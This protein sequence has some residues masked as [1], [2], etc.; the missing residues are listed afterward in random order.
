MVIASLISLHAT[1]L[2]QKMT[3]LGIRLTGER[4]DEELRSLHDW[5]LREPNL[6]QHGQVSLVHKEA[7]PGTMGDLLDLVS[8]LVTSGLQLPA[9]I[10]S[11]I[12]WRNTRT[13]KL[14]LTIEKG[15][16]TI[17]IPDGDPETARKLLETL[18]DED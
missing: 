8:L 16:V 11:L 13:N 5:L 14:P 7:R 3:T 9:F 2:E 17:T 1:I 18:L 15:D 6:R 10:Q 12:T 4:S